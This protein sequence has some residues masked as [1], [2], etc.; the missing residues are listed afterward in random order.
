LLVGGYLLGSIP[1][2]YLIGR[3]YGIDIRKKGSGN[4]GAANILRVIGKKPAAATLLLDA[5]KGFLPTILARQT[6][7]LPSGWIIAVGLA[8][9]IGHTFPVF[10]KFKGGKG[11]ATSL[12]VLIGLSPLTAFFVL[13]VWLVIFAASRIVSLAS[14]AAAIS[15]PPLLWHLANRRLAFLSF[16]AL[17]TVLVFLAHRKNIKRLLSG[18]EPKVKWK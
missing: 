17:I 15:L 6:C 4:I 7:L 16:G 9:I 8:A 2:G 13:L 5:V 12:G 18:Q 11:V 3:S 14:L 10:L 1:F